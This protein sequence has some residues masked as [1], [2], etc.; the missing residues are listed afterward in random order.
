MVSSYPAF[1][2]SSFRPI[3]VLQQTG[4]AGRKEGVVLA[5]QVLIVNNWYPPLPWSSARWSSACG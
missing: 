5:A 3:G 2:L 1:Y 4:A